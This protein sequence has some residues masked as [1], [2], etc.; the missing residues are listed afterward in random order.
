MSSERAL[1][2]VLGGGFV[3]MFL[4]NLHSNHQLNTARRANVEIDGAVITVTCK[5][6][7]H[8]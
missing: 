3:L 6:P 5:E 1:N 4:M 2:W 8:D 7:R